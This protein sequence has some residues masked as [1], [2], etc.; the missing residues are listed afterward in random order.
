MSLSRRFDE[1]T[2]RLE[3]VEAFCRKEP[4]IAGVLQRVYALEQAVL[5]VGQVST[6]AAGL[7]TRV[8]PPPAPAQTPKPEPRPEPIVQRQAEAPAQVEPEPAPEPIVQRQ[9]E[10]PAPQVEPEPT[11]Q[12]E[13][14]RPKMSS[15][16]WEALVGGNWLNKLGVFVLVIGIALFLG[17]SF[18][19]FGPVGRSAIGLGI[20][21]SMLTAGVFTEKRENYRIFARGLIGGG[22]AA[23]YFTTYAMQAVD[24][25]KVIDSPVA[26]ALLLL[27]V[28]AGM[29]SHS[30]RY[31]SQTVT[32]LAYFVAFVTLAITPVTTL[33]VVALIPLAASL[34]YIAYRFSWSAM[35]LLGLIA[36]YGTCASRGDSGA[37]LWSAQAVF[38]IYWLLFEGFDLLQ[39]RRRELYNSWESALLPLNA[40]FFVGLSYAKW[41]TA[42]PDHLFLLAG[43]VAAG[44]FASTVLRAYVRP[45]SS[46]APECETLARAMSGGYEGP[47]TLTALLSIAAIFLKFHG[48]VAQLGLLAE[49]ELLF[50]AGLYF[51]ERYP[52]QLAAALFASALAKLLTLDVVANETTTVA[53]WTMKSWTPV[54]ALNGVLFYLNRA[55]RGEDRFYGYSAAAVF[56][57]IIGA[58]T[59]E[60]YRGLAWFLF[61]AGVFAFGWLR[62][63]FDF[64]V[65]GYALAGLGLLG[66]GMYQ[67]EVAAGVA[68]PLHHPLVAL[69]CSALLAYAA[70]WCALRSGE[71]RLQIGERE[72]MRQTGAWAATVLL[73]VLVWRL[74]PIEYRGL[75]WM[76]LALPLLGLGLRGWPAEFCRQAYLVASAGALTVL[77]VNVIPV[78]NDAPLPQRLAILGAALLAYAIA[79]RVFRAGISEA[80][81]SGEERKYVFDAGSAAGTLFLLV[82]LWALLPSAIAAPAWALAALLLLEI[83]FTL[84]LPSLRLQGH[85]TGG[86]AFSRLFFANFEGLGQVGVVSQRVLT[87]LPVLVSHYYHWSR[88]RSEAI[89]LR[90]WER[91]LG[92][93]Y[94]YSA[95]ILAVVL[96]RF[97]FGRVY[98]VAGWAALALGLMAAG[99]R[100]N[101]PDLRWQSYVIAALAFWRGESTDFFA[102]ESFSE[103]VGRIAVASF[104]IACFY[105]AQISIPRS[106]AEKLD[107]ERYA[108][109]FY[110]L[111]ATVL[112]TTLLYHEVSGSVLT[113]AWGIEGV[114]LLIAGFPLMDRVLRLSGLSLFLVCILK[115]FFY[116]MRH[117]E[118]MYRILSFIA[119]GLILVG[120]SWIYTRF[121][122]RIQRYL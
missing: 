62:R 81:A 71:D 78:R 74:V 8:A 43:A 54:T 88:Q 72:G 86:A 117:L 20:S 17:Y 9:A 21:L 58:E 64:R 25:A 61:A 110:S 80:D 109:L 37:P 73:S 6:P 65:Q 83:G 60:R 120:V 34:L 47:I 106:F 89:R 14:P 12:P 102:P 44:Y 1:L 4:A 32:A 30:L 84:D 27:A 18:T 82:A 93:L 112:L 19:Q 101:I 75:A 48:G 118:T 13:P 35:A 105:A 92:R 36:T 52:R 23:L 33:S 69:G 98:A 100:W 2:Q 38:T 45:P 15:R 29:I 99:L 56:A 10:A 116:D 42:A 5:H 40:L 39:A 91:N 96:M 77:A 41:S 85:L 24:A 108:R 115:L 50:V 55:L 114:A 95:A 49:A 111:L 68:E 122:D 28:A 16:E 70:V 11:P 26:G 121:R 90:E 59:P 53:G 3:T 66:T 107:L 31:R 119:L 113:V 104:V 7:Q 97:E 67:L 46:F 94:L 63:L 22:W 76:A 103:A 79:A 57:L 87:V 51:R